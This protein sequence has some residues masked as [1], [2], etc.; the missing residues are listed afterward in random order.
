MVL[1]CN[2]M[3]ERCKVRL[4][5]SPALIVRSF[6]VVVDKLGQT[7]PFWLVMKVEQVDKYASIQVF[8]YSSIQVFIDCQ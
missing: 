3:L 1:G 6:W 5:L 4:C 7:L 2:R 8:K